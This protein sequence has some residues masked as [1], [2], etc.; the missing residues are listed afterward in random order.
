M[1]FKFS[2]LHE[3]CLHIAL[4]TVRKTLVHYLKIWGLQSIKPSKA[5]V[6]S[7]IKYVIGSMSQQRF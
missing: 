2:R 5:K 6:N 3:G 7:A 4:V 1:M